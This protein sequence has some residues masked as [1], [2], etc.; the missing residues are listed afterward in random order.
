MEE[1]EKS[2]KILSLERHIQ[3][4]SEE[5]Y[6]LKGQQSSWK[7]NNEKV[8]KKNADNFKKILHL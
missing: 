6:V 5:Y 4:I 1:S 2:R 8:E 7:R 3:S